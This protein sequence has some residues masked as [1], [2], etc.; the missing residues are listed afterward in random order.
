MRLGPAIGALSVGTAFLMAG[1]GIAA[2]DAPAD[3]AT[4]PGGG[5][6]SASP[7]KAAATRTAQRGASRDP[8]GIGIAPAAARVAGKSERR[9]A[10]PSANQSTGVLGRVAALLN[11]QTPR[12]SPTQSVQSSAGVVSGSLNAVDPDSPLLGFTVTSAPAHGSATV[13]VD[14][15]WTYTPD[16]PVATAGTT[17][18]FVVEVSDAPSGFAVHGLAGLLHLLSFGLFGTRGDTST[19]T[20]SVTVAPLSPDPPR[21]DRFQPGDLVFEGFFRVPTGQ[22]GASEYA[23]LAYGGAAMASRVVDGQRRFLLTGHRYANDPLIELV[24]PE[25]LASTPDAAPVAAVFRYWGDIYGGLKV[26][27]DEPDPSE[28]NANWTEGLLWDDAGQRLLWSYG[29]WYAASGANNPVLGATVLGA[30]GR[31]TVQG[32]WRT[33]AP[34]QQTRSFAVELSPAVS[35]ASGGAALGLGGKMQSINATASWGPSLHAITVPTANLPVGTTL[36]ARPLASHP[37]DPTGRRSPRAADYQVARNPDG[38]VDTA[39]TEPT[40]GGAGYWTELD[41][42]SGAAFVRSGSGDRGALVYSGGQAY[43]LIWYGNDL[44]HGVAD[45]RGYNGSGNHAESYR[46]VLWFVS[47]ADLAAAASGGLAPHEV[48]PYATV[49]LVAQ[50]PQLAPVAGLSAG[51]PVFAEDEARLYVPFP[52]GTVLDGQPF[53]LV[54]VFAVAD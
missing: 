45:G 18:S 39:G 31:M 8:G 4:A 51:Q 48:N 15:A 54:A 7:A 41:E 29:N 23:T 35:A 12:M 1:A 43:G 34:S 9:P 17:D 28:P 6:D 14:G 42:T 27:A 38:S 49:D 33:T 40:A 3:A 20:V 50:F 16:P 47:E 25:G 36:D 37:I 2:A 52:G 10:R 46:P 44:E 53:P 24:A 19:S 30:D 11:N 5:R 32:P 13:A 26:T 22:L 21:A